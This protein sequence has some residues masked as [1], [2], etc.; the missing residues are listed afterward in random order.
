MLNDLLQ[1]TNSPAFV[2]R[3]DLRVL[4]VHCRPAE[5]ADVFLTVDVRLEDEHTY[6]ETA[7]AWQIRCVEATYGFSNSLRDYKRPYNQ[8]RLYAD[9]PVLFNYAHGVEIEVRGMCPHVPALLGDLYEA[10]GQACGHWVDFAWHFSHLATHLRAHQRV[11]LL[12]PT[13]LVEVYGAVFAHHG[14]THTLQG[15]PT[16]A[17][18][19]SPLQALLFSNPLVCPDTFNLGQPYQVAPAFEAHRMG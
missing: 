8:L 13:P 18:L 17:W 16:S 14:L 11:D 6:E 5:S 12:W 3:G 19:D 9:H 4:E 2:E 10:H 7:Q 1:L 15:S